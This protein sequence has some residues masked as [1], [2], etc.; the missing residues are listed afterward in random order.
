MKV[1][2]ASPAKYI[3][4]TTGLFDLVKKFERRINKAGDKLQRNYMRLYTL[5]LEK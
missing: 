4:N 5:E 2:G 3:E 1:Y